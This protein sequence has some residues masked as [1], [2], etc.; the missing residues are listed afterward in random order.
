MRRNPMT[1]RKMDGAGSGEGVVS[2][3]SRLGS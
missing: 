3:V 2:I 1:Y